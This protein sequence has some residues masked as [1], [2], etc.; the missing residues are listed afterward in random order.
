[1]KLSEYI[2][3]QFGNPRGLIGNICCLIMNIINRKLY[4]GIVD[5][6]E[7]AKDHCVLDIGYGNGYLTKLIH[8]RFA[9]E[10]FG[11]DIS[12]DMKKNATKRNKKAVAENRIHLD[13]GDCC[14]LSFQDDLF[15]AVVSVN[16][17]Y[18]W[19][20][21]RKGLLE[22]YRTLKKGG[23]FS[24]AIYSKEWMQKT[25]YTE[26]GFKLFNPDEIESLA[27]EIG[28]KDVKILSLKAG[29]AFIINCHK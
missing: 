11:I 18:F 9:T 24:N 20:D 8:R 5:S 7:L 12:E 22:I 3:S 4:L 19:N 16:T 25:T 29:K 28:F 2:G 27:K 6:L 15:E 10:I 1:M 26:K 13:L 17:I 14:D 23:V 21:T